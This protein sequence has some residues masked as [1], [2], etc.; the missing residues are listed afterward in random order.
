MVKKAISG[1]NQKLELS[2]LIKIIIGFGLLLLVYEFFYLDI[3]NLWWPLLILLPPFL[4]IVFVAL[5][6]FSVIFI[7]F[8]FKYISWKAFFPVMISGFVLLISIY[9]FYP[10]RYFRINIEFM[11]KSRGFEEVITMVENGDLRPDNYGEANLPKEYQYLSSDD[12]VSIYKEN[13]V[14]YVSFDT[15]TAIVFPKANFMY[16]SNQLPPDVDIRL[17]VYKINPHWYLVSYL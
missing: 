7:F 10:I 17:N 6:I 16:S 4:G 9:L 13:D 15:N 11:A 2:H 8:Y 5:G 12:K 14:L 3:Y 1:L